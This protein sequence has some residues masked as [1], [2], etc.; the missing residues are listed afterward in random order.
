MAPKG[1]QFLLHTKVYPVRIDEGFL[2]H[3]DVFV[4]QLLPGKCDPFIFQKNDSAFFGGRCTAGWQTMHLDPSL[5]QAI[6]KTPY[7]L[8]NIVGSYCEWLNTILH[9]WVSLKLSTMKHCKQGD[10]K[11]I[12][13]TKWCK[14][15][16]I[17]SS[18]PYS[19]LQWPRK[20]SEYKQ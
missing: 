4:T 2:Q 6:E 12:L 14:I 17:H 18:F 5:H 11:V 15:S 9:Q 3:F 13:S 10:Y 7:P 20:I 19:W 16:S 8:L 1:N